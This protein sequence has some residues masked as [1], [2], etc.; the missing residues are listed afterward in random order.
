KS[1]S[2]ALFCVGKTA[3]GGQPLAAGFVLQACELHCLSPSS[4]HVL[5]Q[6]S[7]EGQKEMLCSLKITGATGKKQQHCIEQGNRF[8]LIKTCC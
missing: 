5:Q 6:I 3:G 4:G 2:L 8:Q 1:D 7:S